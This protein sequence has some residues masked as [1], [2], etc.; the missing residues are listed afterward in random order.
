VDAAV[1]SA[2]VTMLAVVHSPWW[3]AAY[4]VVALVCWTRIALSYHTIAQTAAGTALGMA[5]AALWLL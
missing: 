4:S 1:A 2:V 3:A 5:T